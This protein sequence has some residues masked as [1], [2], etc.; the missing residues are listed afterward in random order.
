LRNLPDWELIC[1]ARLRT[2][3]SQFQP[4]ISLSAEGFAARIGFAERPWVQNYRL[5]EAW[6]FVIHASTNS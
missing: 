4:F 2:E 3:H 1:A 5:R 6:S